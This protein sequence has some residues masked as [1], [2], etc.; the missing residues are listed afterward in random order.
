MNILAIGNSYSQDA[1][2]YLAQMAACADINA[3]VVN[4]YIGGCSL[5]THFNNLIAEKPSY[6]YELN[7][8]RTE[9]MVSIQEAVGERAWDVITMQQVSNQSVDYATYQPHLGILSAYLKK[10][11]P[12]A[13]QALHQTWGYAPGTE[14]ILSLG[15]KT[16]PE[17]FEKSEAAYRE[18]A[19][20]TGI[21]ILIPAGRALCK[22]YEAG[23]SPLYRDDIHASLGL[24]RYILGGVWYEI[25]F[26]KDFRENPFS[27]TDEPITEAIR[28]QATEIVHTV[29]RAYKK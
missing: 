4:L 18:A 7:G 1:T 3:T 11:A 25:L 2:R 14:H 17:M 10:N 24:G 9:R 21:D 15:F 26:G 8:E 19:D 13:R 22:A 12:A 27:D 23:L 6:A 28:A 20:E 5:E 29:T 16:P